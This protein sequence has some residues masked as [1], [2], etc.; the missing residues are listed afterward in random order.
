MVKKIPLQNGMFAL[1]DDEDYERCMEYVWNSNRRTTVNGLNVV[2]RIDGKTTT[3][4]NFI[5]KDTEKLLKTHANGN[6]FDYRK[7]N[8]KFIEPSFA[9]ISRKGARG[10][11]SKYK[12]VFR[13]KNAK[14]W[15]AKIRKDGHLKHLGTFISEDDAARAY[16][17][18][19][20]ELFGEGCY[21]NI[22]GENN[23]SEILNIPTVSQVRKKGKVGY[24]GVSLSK[25]RS[26]PFRARIWVD[27]KESVIGY[28][29]TKTE[30]AL[31]YDKK[32]KEL[33][34]DKA[35]LNFPNLDEQMEE[36]K[37]KV[38][39]AADGL[40]GKLEGFERSSTD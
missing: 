31:A 28:F 4:L 33:Y 38:N 35:I 20:M 7:E 13:R 18:A 3:L 23:N 11:S 30:A 8:I 21:L 15:Q 39:I 9:R 2:T 27:G 12:G 32:A 26:K 22:I 24:K 40:K 5:F 14:K 29:A 16:N 36:I 10:S 19:A 1:V 17:K 6:L 37:K 25:S 34:G